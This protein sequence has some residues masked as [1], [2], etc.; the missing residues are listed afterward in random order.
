MITSI[1]ASLSAL[2]IIKLAFSVIKL[3]RKNKISVGDIES[4]I[5]AACRA[6]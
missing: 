4:A 1:Y 6:A 3:R 2:L 5:F